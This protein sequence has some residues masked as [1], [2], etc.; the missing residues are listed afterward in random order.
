MTSV[1]YWVNTWGDHRHDWS[2]GHTTGHADDRLVLRREHYFQFLD[3]G[4]YYCWCF[5]PK[6]R[7]FL[8]DVKFLCHVLFLSALRNQSHSLHLLASMHP[9]TLFLVFRGFSFP[10]TFL[11]WPSVIRSRVLRDAQSNFSVFFLKISI[12]E[13]LSSTIPNICS[14]DAC[15]VQGIFIIRRQIHISKAS[16][17]PI[18]SCLNV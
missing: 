11:W 10:E 17:L 18:S 13:R 5:L 9:I 7:F 14:F 15:C 1:A 3:S 8:I 2:A 16:R 4:N 12:K 6:G